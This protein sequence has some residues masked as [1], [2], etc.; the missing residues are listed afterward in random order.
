VLH[1]AAARNMLAHVIDLTERGVIA[2]QGA[3][4]ADA[5]FGLV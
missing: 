5:V 1:G 4:S 2:P 3:F